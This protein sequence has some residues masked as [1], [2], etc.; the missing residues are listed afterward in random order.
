MSFKFIENKLREIVATNFGVDVNDLC[1]KTTNGITFM[2]NTHPDLEKLPFNGLR[3]AKTSGSSM[4]ELLVLLLKSIAT[5]LSFNSA[6]GSKC[7]AKSTP[8]SIY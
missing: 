4:E 2:V 8:T 7:S 1:V 5:N 3:L 6:A